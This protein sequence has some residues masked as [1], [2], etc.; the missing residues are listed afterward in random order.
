MDSLK[1]TK[2]KVIKELYQIA[3]DVHSI[4]ETYGL[5]YWLIGGSFLG[6][7]RHQGIIPW[8]DDLDLGIKKTDVNKFLKLRKIFYRC[9]YKIVSTWFGY[10]IFKINKK[11]LSGFNYAFPNCDIFVYKKFTD[12][13]ILNH[14]SARDAWPKDFYPTYEI[15]NLKKYKFGMF[16]L[17]GPNS[18]K[19]Y[20]NRLYGKDW[21]DVAYR[22]YDHSKE[23]E[24]TKVKVKLR[25]KDRFPAEPYDLINTHKC[26]KKMCIR[27]NKIN[28]YKY[29][30]S[31]TSHNLS[32]LPDN[33]NFDENIGTYVINCD[34]HSD[35]LNKFKNY[36]KIAK[37][38]YIRYPCIKGYEFDNSVICKMKKAGILAK[39]AE[40]NPIEISINLSH[41]NV[42]QTMINN[43]QDYALVMEDDS[44]PSKNFVKTVNNIV[45]KLLDKDIQFDI[46]FLWNG[47][48]MQTKSKQKY[49][50]TVDNID[51]YQERTYYNAG[52]VAY[53][54]SNEFAQ[55]VLEKKAY[56]IKY[57]Q[58]MLLGGLVNHGIHLSVHMKYD[59][60]QQ[61]YISKLLGNPCLGGEG[62]TGVSTQNYDSVNVNN[63][64]CDSCNIK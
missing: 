52:A 18:Y 2:P 43:N 12:K 63:Y 15:D 6:A 10:K 44:E 26:F 61:C 47:N 16:K 1:I 36:A 23:A 4:F 45:N 35:R 41:Y 24:V 54:I 55:Y 14:K 5:K 53:I 28:I 56:P 64:G 50:T 31:P 8:D 3:Y 48:W 29:I 7:I 39:N 21:N 37:L 51:I 38:K 11:L 46:L 32:D 17:F 30:V 60:S 22:E 57:P 19:Q 40:M 13:Y 9:G 49:I 58:D 25:K 33:S 34:I 62:G 42:W 20:F 27:K 59:K